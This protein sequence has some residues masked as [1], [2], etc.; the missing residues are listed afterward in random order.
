MR[1]YSRAATQAAARQILETG[2]EDYEKHREEAL[3]EFIRTPRWVF[4]YEEKLNILRQGVWQFYANA[5]A[6]R[7]P[8]SVLPEEGFEYYLLENPY[9]KTV[10]W[11]CEKAGFLVGQYR[12]I[13]GHE[14]FAISHFCPRGPLGGR[15]L[16]EAVR[17]QR[18]MIPFLQVTEDLQGMLRRLG[19]EPVGTGDHWFRDEYVEKY[20]FTNADNAKLVRL[21]LR[22]YIG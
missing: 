16:L 8:D 1:Q 4:S 11:G 6:K 17:D 9:G 3:E 18:E 21:A 19:F 10:A 14:I 7:R 20:S 5:M 2:L 13:W 22:Y 12:E 15:R